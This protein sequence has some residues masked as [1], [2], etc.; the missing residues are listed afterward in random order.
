[1]SSCNSVVKELTYSTTKRLVGVYF[2]IAD[3]KLSIYI[4]TCWLQHSMQFCKPLW[5][6]ENKIVFVGLG[7]TTLTIQ[8]GKEGR[9]DPTN[10]DIRRGV[11]DHHSSFKQC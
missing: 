4:M 9:N 7:H 5:A 8:N 2:M 11:H 10:Q 3:A 1:V 6:V